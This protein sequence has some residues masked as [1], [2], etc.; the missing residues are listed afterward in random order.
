MNN[1]TILFYPHTRKNQ[2]SFI[3]CRILIKKIKNEEN[4]GSVVQFS[5]GLKINRS[6]WCIDT[7]RIRGKSKET[8]RINKELNRIE[9]ELHSIIADYRFRGQPLS[10]RRVFQTYKSGYLPWLAKN[11]LDEYVSNKLEDKSIVKASKSKYK[12]V[13]VHFNN[14]LDSL[15]REVFLDDI[16]EGFILKYLSYLQN[17]LNHGEAYA[18]K[19]VYVIRSMVRYAV[20]NEYIQIDKLSGLTYPKKEKRKPIIYLTDNELTRIS[21]YVFTSDRLQRIVDLFIFQSWTGFA[22]I[23]TQTFDLQKDLHYV[24]GKYFIIK[25]RS[26]S[27]GESMMLPL[28]LPAYEILQKYDFQLPKISNTNYNKY[29]KEV[30]RMAG[31]DKNL[32]THVARR[33][34]AMKFLNAGI[35]QEVVAQMMGHS[36]QMLKKHYG[37]IL[38]RRVLNESIKHLPNELLVSFDHENYYSIPQQSNQ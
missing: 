26:K 4:S 28:F 9:T 18:F 8:K 32:T 16:N 37:R 25:Y 19:N 21:L 36:V 22:Y 30:A 34:S 12:T 33:T 24:D 31:I 29:L 17:T 5:T 14:F 15:G 13:Q 1:Y 23:D 27:T 20:R 6:D 7:K 2:N 10:A 38:P 3:T 11:V 35:S